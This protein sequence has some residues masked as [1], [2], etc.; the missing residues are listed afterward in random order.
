M[1]NLLTENQISKIFNINLITLKKLVHEGKI[2]FITQGSRPRFDMGAISNWV[3]NNPLM[4][5]EEEI[6]LNKIQAEW[7]EKSP[8]VFAVLQAMD[9]KVIAHSNAQKN[10][11]RYSLI[12]RPSK[13]IWLSLLCTLH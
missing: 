8:E 10:P 9:Q 5:N 2:P 13:K 1:D 12:K 4:E 3:I 6:Y 7:R 11:K